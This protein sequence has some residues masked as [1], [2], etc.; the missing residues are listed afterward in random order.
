VTRPAISVEIRRSMVSAAG[1]G[2]ETTP[3]GG[4]AA[5]TS[6]VPTAARPDAADNA[7]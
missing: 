6:V 4:R 3:A 7:D 5:D 1:W 2:R